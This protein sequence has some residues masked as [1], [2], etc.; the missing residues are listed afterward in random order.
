MICNPPPNL[1]P[2]TARSFLA[3][4]NSGKL[5][6]LA[7]APNGNITVGSVDAAETVVWLDGISFD[8]A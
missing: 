4:G 7:A 2:K 8:V 5:A 1:Q 3:S 6:S